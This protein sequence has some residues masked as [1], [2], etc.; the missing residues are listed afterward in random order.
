NPNAGVAG[1]LFLNTDDKEERV[2]QYSA[3]TINSDSQILRKTLLAI[4]ERV[5]Q[6]NS[7][8]VSQTVCSLLEKG[9]AGI[10]GPRVSATSPHVQ[11]ICDTMDIPHVETSWGT[12]HRRQDFLVNLYP[13][14]S[15][16]AKLYVEMV[17]AWG[18]KSFTLLYEDAASLVRLSS[19]LQMFDSSGQAFTM[20]QLD[21]HGNHRDVLR[22][23]RQ[24]GERNIVLDCSV[25]GLPEVLKQAQ[26][27]GLMTSDQSYIITC[28]DLHT[29]DLEPY[30]HG[31]TNITGLRMVDPDSE[32]VQMAVKHWG[33]LE[34]RRGRS[35]GIT[36][37]DITVSMAL[38][39][40][41]VQ[42]FARAL[43]RLDS[44]L[45]D[46]KPLSCE[47][48]DNWGHGASLINFM[49][50]GQSTLRGLT[51]I[52]QF[53]NE[54]FRSNIVLD[55]MEL[56]EV[57][58]MRVG[59]WNSTEGLNITRA[60][61]PSV[62][63]DSDSLQNRT[64]IVLTA[65]SE[66]YGMLRRS[67]ESLTGNDRFEGFG[68]QL[69]QELSLMLGFN[70]TF[71]LEQAYGSYNKE[72][73]EWNGMIRALQ[74]RKADLAITDLTI[75]SEREGAADFTMPFMSLGISILYKRPTK[76]AP[77]LFSFMSPFSL[78]V[79]VCMFS[80]YVGVSILLWI[81]G[82]LCPYEWN[83]PYPC[84]EEPDELENQFTLRNSMWFTI[85]SLMQQGSEIAPIAVS[86][87]MVAGIWWFFTLIIVSSYTANLAA[88]LT[89]E[90]L[91]SPFKNVRELANQNVIKY[92]AKAGGSTVNFFRDST[93]PLY[94]KMYEYMDMNKAEV[95]TTSNEQGLEWVKTRNYAY[96]MES[97]SIEYYT[98]RN[99]EVAQVGD[100]LDSK[101]Y[102]IAMRKNSTIRNQLSTAVLKMQESGKLAKMKARW[103]KEEREGGKCAAVA[104]SGNPSS[105]NLGNVGGVFVVLVGGLVLS[106]FTAT[107]ELL[108]HV[109]EVSQKEKVPFRDVLLSEMRFITRCHGSTKTIRKYNSQEKED[110][111]QDEAHNFPLY[112]ASPYGFNGN[113][114]QP[115]T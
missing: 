101:G 96:F 11:S 81:M 58:L 36:P 23:M 12:N 30:Q 26:Q 106:C 75:T 113:M 61:P 15:T 48:K 9:V 43:R 69:I 55:I 71:Q 42:L 31:G 25:E 19:L 76:E 45:V 24:S 16:L 44:P 33:D 5:N 28:L 51:G 27:I 56:T 115:L 99:C 68:I 74:D 60:M 32:I 90:S 64:F 109:Y 102:G 103:W 40:D 7:L 79:W 3:H 110:S 38:I 84:I 95:M 20:R 93:D 6:D 35:L 85:G 50:D 83:N 111:P 21:P 70:Y 66:P 100:L 34:S 47:S 10:F 105:L 4:P 87:R 1:G 52:V 73:G 53:D 14:S 17:S 89:V 39:H 54:G 97:T 65:L 94:R 57:G 80:V 2:F 13:H 82:R 88:F 92:G 107:F 72:T 59:S 62:A 112:G 86:T 114:K 18:W 67:S 98:E 46:I 29:I 41:A 37:H 77:K 104:G 8:Q 78:D 49:K 63:H 108:C 22:A 91:T